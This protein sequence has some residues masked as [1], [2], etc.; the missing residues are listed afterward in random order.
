[1][2]STLLCSQVWSGEGDSAPELDVP[3]RGE[4]ASYIGPSMIGS[5]DPLHTIR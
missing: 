4:R 2:L 5:G 1:M 3:G